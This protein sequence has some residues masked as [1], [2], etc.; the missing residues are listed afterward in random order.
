MVDFLVF[1]L[2][3]CILFGVE[4]TRSFIF[5]AFGFIAWIAIGIAALCIIAKL[6]GADKTEAERKTE[7]KHAAERKAAELENERQ[8]KEE[9]RRIDE[10]F[11]R[12]DPKGYRRHNF[13]L[14]GFMVFLVV[15]SILAIAACA[16]MVLTSK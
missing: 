10:E 7:A 4:A 8:L 3:L 9:A 16:I 6:V 11:K 12:K 15:F 5:G 1:L 14:K 2:I 13:L